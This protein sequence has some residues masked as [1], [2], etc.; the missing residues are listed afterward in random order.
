MLE[1]NRIGR[2]KRHEDFVT[3]GGGALLSVP[4]SDVF[5]PNLYK[6]F[7]F[8]FWGEHCAECTAPDCYF[9]C[10]L[11]ERGSTGWC[12]RFADGIV[13]KRY[14]KGKIPYV[15]EVLFK[16]WGRLLAVGNTMCISSAYFRGFVRL[17]LICGWIWEKCKLMFCFLPVRTQWW[18]TDKMRGAGNRIPLIMNKLASR[19]KNG[20]NVFV[21]IIGN[22]HNEDM[23][24]EVVLSGIQI[25]T[26]TGRRDSQDGRIFRRQWQV[27]HGWHRFEVPVSEIEASIDLRKPFRISL[28]PV[29]DSLRLVQIA[30][31]GFAVRKLLEM[32]DTGKREKKIKLLVMDLDN[33]VWDGIVI[34][35]PDAEKLLDLLPEVKTTLEGLD[36]RGI[37][38]SVA[39]K[40]NEVDSRKLLEKHGLW[41]LMLYPQINW[42]PKSM[43][44]RRIVESLNI[45][46]DTVAFIDDSEFE[47]AEVKTNLPEVRVYRASDF[48]FLLEREEFDVPVTDESSKRRMLYKAEIKRQSEFTISNL[49]YDEFLAA[50]KMEMTLLTLDSANKERVYEL[51]Q[52]TNQ[53]NFSGRHYSRS[54]LDDILQKKEFIPVVISCSDRFGDYGIVGFAFLRCRNNMLEIVDMMFSCRIQGKKV[55]HS[56][57][58]YLLK[59]C[60]AEELVC[61][62]VRTARN[63]HAVRVFF[64]LNFTEHVVSED[65][66]RMEY[67]YIRKCS[68]DRLEQQFPVA[69]FDKAQLVET[70]NRKFSSDVD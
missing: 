7:S 15:Y 59:L 11:F 19:R 47:L 40:G 24:M 27:G 2:S 16:P 51:V 34:E 33:T 52:R 14:P 68:A 42:E 5:S 64:D 35:N 21:F 67:K 37:L 61:F 25:R 62:F 26:Q 57:L 13:A 56:F 18:I 46:M 66:N 53:L 23:I 31:A 54:Q 4:S 29:T 43:N 3:A 38:L 6:A 36:R 39:G 50:C 10:D 32:S 65:S 55:E 45:G 12:K 9:T 70:I 20:A 1:L 49:S 28:D 17:F 69:V 44:I 22:S 8:Q 48:P 41:D 30:Y 63:K 58:A 60:R